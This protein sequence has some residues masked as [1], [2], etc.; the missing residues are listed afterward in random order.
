MLF[1][2]TV[3]VVTCAEP[4]SVTV[5]AAPDSVTV[6]PSPGRVTVVGIVTVV[7]SPD[8]ET[9]TTEVTV[10]AVQ[11]EPEPPVAEPLMVAMVDPVLRQEQAL[12]TREAGMLTATNDG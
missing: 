6:V 1:V 8:A 10:A 2:K 5:V 4:D 3:T 11:E 7:D 9:V 12:E